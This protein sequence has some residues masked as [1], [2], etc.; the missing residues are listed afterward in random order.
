[1]G[2]GDAF[3]RIQNLFIIMLTSFLSETQPDSSIPNPVCMLKMII[4]AV[5]CNNASSHS[6]PSNA[7]RSGMV[8]SSQA[9]GVVAFS[10]QLLSVRMLDILTK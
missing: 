7:G 1:M 9:F 4:E 2:A 3:L 6:H 5:T 10:I 8:V